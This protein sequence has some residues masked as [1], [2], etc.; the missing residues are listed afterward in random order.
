[1]LRVERARVYDIMLMVSLA[2]LIAPAQHDN[3]LLHT[4]MFYC[5][6]YV[7]NKNR[8]RYCKL[9]F[10]V[11]P[12][13]LT[14]FNQLIETGKISLFK[15]YTILVFQKL[16]QCIDTPDFFYSDETEYLFWW[17]FQF[18]V[19]LTTNPLKSSLNKYSHSTNPQHTIHTSSTRIQS[20]V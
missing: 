2:S 12:H 15:G 3:S 19:V 9:R 20:Y 18:L 13:L 14:C 10:S 17:F 5:L 16:L 7:Q 4:C 11:Y 8:N 6:I 1:M